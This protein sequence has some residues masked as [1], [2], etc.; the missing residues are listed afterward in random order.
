MSAQTALGVIGILAVCARVGSLR[1]RLEGTWLRWSY[2]DLQVRSGGSLRQG[3]LY[4]LV[5]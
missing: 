5:Q 2:S 3:S 4:G 1:E